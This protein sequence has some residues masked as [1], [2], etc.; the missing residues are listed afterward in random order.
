MTAPERTVLDWSGA[1]HWSWLQA[2]CIHCEDLTR[3]VD[4]AGRPSHRTCA[5]RFIDAARQSPPEPASAHSGGP[6]TLCRLCGGAISPAWAGQHD[7]CPDCWQVLLDAQDPVPC[8][9]CARVLDPTFASSGA[10]SHPYCD[11]GT[12]DQAATDR[13]IRLVHDRLGGVAVP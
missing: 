10:T 5:E 4:G 3:L 6:H 12:A 2:G 8:T 1:E 13:A 9:V 11:P 7:R